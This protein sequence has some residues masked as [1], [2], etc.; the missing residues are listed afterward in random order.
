MAAKFNA[1]PVVPA[2][3]TQP[4]VEE[5]VIEPSYFYKVLCSNRYQLWV[6]QTKQGSLE[7]CQ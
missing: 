3:E 7:G 4:H 6:Q 5:V 1:Q 2:K